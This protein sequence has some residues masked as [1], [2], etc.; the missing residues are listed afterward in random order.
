MADDKKKG[1]ASLYD[2]SPSMK[3]R[4]KESAAT[5]EADMEKGDK[6]KADSKAADKGID[7]LES[8]SE[9]F[10]KAIGEVRKRHESERRDFHGNHREMLR[11][12][13]ARHDKEIGMLIEQHSPREGNANEADGGT[14]MPGG[15][16]VVDGME[17]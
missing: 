8:A 16:A 14:S 7:K 6:P 12:M 13:A 10:L 11:S 4:E 5:A 15:A 3:R 9:K 2:N 1:A 17:G